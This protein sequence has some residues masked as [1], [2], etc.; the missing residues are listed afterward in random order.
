MKKSIYEL[1]L[2]KS[3]TV[4]NEFYEASPVVRSGNDPIAELREN[5]QLKQALEKLL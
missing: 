3:T 2:D 1:E 5:G 4:N